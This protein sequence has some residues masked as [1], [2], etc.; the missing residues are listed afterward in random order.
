MDEANLIKLI[1]EVRKRKQNIGQLEQQ[2]AQ[3]S[4]VE[5]PVTNLDKVTKQ[6]EDLKGRKTELN[7]NINKESGSLT[8]ME[9]SFA[10]QLSEASKEEQKLIQ[11]RFNA[12]A[13]EAILACND[14]KHYV[15]S[16][17]LAKQM[18]SILRGRELMPLKDDLM[19]KV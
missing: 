15:A 2:L 8:H 12:L 19:E 3:L 7:A 16:S 18:N 9:T 11:M 6:I 10:E 14:Q 5:E 17:D 1:E 4:A 13:C